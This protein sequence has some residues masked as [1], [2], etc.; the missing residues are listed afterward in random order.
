MRKKLAKWKPR[1]LSLAGRIALAKAVLAATPIYAM[2][3]T[4][5]PKGVCSEMD[6]II[7]NFVWGHMEKKGINLVKWD[8]IC[9][10]TKR[11]V[12]F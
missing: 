1:L 4:V 2:Q 5:T 9:K 12:D 8:D 7:H 11:D 6:K 3:T 10:T